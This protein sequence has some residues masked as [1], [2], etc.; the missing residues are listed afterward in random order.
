MSDIHALSGAYSVDA[1]DDIERARFERHLAECPECRAEVDSLRETAALLADRVSAGPPPGLRGRV[2]ADIATVRPLPPLTVTPHRRRFRPGALV[3][4]AAAVI[5]LAGGAAVWQPWDDDPSQQQPALSATDRVLR[6]DDA[7]TYTQQLP[8]G[9]TVTV[10]R[11][12]SLNQAVLET[13]G[14]RELPSDQVYEM[15]FAHQSDGGADMVPAGLMDS[16][17]GAFLME[18]DAADAVGVGITV[19][20]AGGSE[21]PTL[22]PV[23]TIAFE[24]A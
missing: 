15:W 1:L 17:E 23:T 3:A 10:T 16:P 21:E 8:G 12:P 11:S 20:P 9:A 13:E 24:D 5:A 2:L 4:A 6:A 22:P 14:F 19:E 7:E 18:G